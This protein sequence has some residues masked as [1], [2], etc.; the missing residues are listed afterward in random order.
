MAGIRYCESCGALLQDNFRFC[1]VCGT[2]VRVLASGPS[3]V[4]S[5]YGPD[6]TAPGYGDVPDFS[7]RDYGYEGYDI[8]VPG[9]MTGRNEE[10]VGAV[11][12]PANGDVNLYPGDIHTEILG[13]SP[14]NHPGGGYPGPVPG[15]DV[16]RGY[17]GSGYD[18]YPGDV[19]S[20]SIPV[21]DGFD[22]GGVDDMSA[23][24]DSRS[25]E[26]AVK[27]KLKSSMGSGSAGAK[28]AAVSEEVRPYFK[29]GGDL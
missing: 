8:G 20:D 28:G 14:E 18:V 3:G 12:P 29:E 21:P 25:D 24:W 5:E 9:R 17:P 6:V 2:P 26:P 7:G 19:P 13:R 15:G 4:P 11:P 10:F 27:P 22:R 1:E 16:Y 23:R